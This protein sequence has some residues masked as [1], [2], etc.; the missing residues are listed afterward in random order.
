[1]SVYS[2]VNHVNMN[3]VDG[4]TKVGTYSLDGKLNVVDKTDVNT[5][6]G[7][8]DT[9][10]GATN[11]TY[12]SSISTK[13]GAY[14]PNGSLYIVAT[15]GEFP[16]PNDFNT[17]GLSA[18]GFV[19]V[20]R[21]DGSDYFTGK[22]PNPALEALPQ[23]RIGACRELFEAGEEYIVYKAADFNEAMLQIKIIGGFYTY[24]F[25]QVIT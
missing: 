9:L 18:F 21:V 23:C 22:E 3:L 13:V 25:G 5:F 12:L 19:R 11:V 4:Y 1:M 7:V 2:T 8:S 17:G 6:V 20:P 16:G 15:S 14:A 10:S 24:P